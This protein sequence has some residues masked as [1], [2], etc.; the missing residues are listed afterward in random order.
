MKALLVAGTASALIAG[1]LYLA[2]SFAAGTFDIST[3]SEFGRLI[4]AIVWVTS[5]VNAYLFATEECGP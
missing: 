1:I 5:T 2:G 4:L 3:W